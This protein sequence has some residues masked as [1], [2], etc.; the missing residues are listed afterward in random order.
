MGSFLPGPTDAGPDVPVVTTP[1]QKERGSAFAE[2]LKAAAWVEYIVNA[3]AVLIGGFLQKAINALAGVFDRILALIVPFVTAGQGI[4]TG[5]FYDLVAAILSD[6]LGVEVSSDS[7]QEAH[8]KRG[9]I[10]AMQAAGG[11]F[12][13]V[14]AN[15]FLG[16][17]QG[18]EAGEGISGLPGAE[19]TPLTPQQ[20][21][22]AAKAFLGFVLSFSVR[23]GNV[24][25]LT[26]ALSIHLL[27][28]IREY[29]EQMASN[30]G[31]SR[32]ARMAMKPLMTTLVASPLQEGLNRQYRPH[33]MDAKQIASAFIRGELD[34]SDYADRL[35]G[36]GYKE[37]DID[38]LIA[39]TYNRLPFADLF[40]LHENGVITDQDLNAR[41]ASLGFNTSDVP[42]MIQARQYGAVQGADRKYAEILAAELFEGTISQTDYDDQF[43][44]LRIPK[45]EADALSRNAVAARNHK[46]KKLS[47]GFL[48]KAY[49]DASITLDEYIAHVKELGYSQED[50]DILEVELLFAQKTNAAHAATKAAAAAKKAAGKTPTKPPGA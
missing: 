20:G 19:G 3:L 5:G 12:F 4:G 48:R 18:A 32:L 50:V 17:G 38:L 16:K 6:L 25:V 21:V 36:L 2:G 47:L 43:A 39:D 1:D 41:I 11:D 14:L 7:L 49:L 15:E 29:G 44:R 27:G 24:A 34:R 8:A 22:D 26:D 45:L 35:R 28:Q 42:L 9:T 10:G 30:L 23:Q 40:I 37:G 46:H 31:L 13:N 33:T